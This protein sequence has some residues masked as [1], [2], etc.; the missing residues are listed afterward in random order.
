MVYRILI[1]DIPHRYCCHCKEFHPLN[2]KY[3]GKK[4]GK[5]SECK[6]RVRQYRQT[7]AWKK[8]MVKSNQK[9]WAVR[10]VVTSR[11]EDKMRNRYN[12]VGYIDKN[13]LE[14]QL[15]RQNSRCFYCGS[16]MEYGVGFSRTSRRGLTV[17]RLDNSKGHLK[18]NCVLCCSGC[19]HINHPCR[20]K[21][22][23]S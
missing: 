2:T 13:F 10:M 23:V 18:T 6:I 8:S 9:N 12:P 7:E 11:S 20:K 1:N 4:R 19:Q 15:I 5:L 17:E 21:Q 14:M 16:R 22:K 3:W